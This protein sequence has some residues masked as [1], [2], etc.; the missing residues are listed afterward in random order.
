MPLA[1]GHPGH[2]HHRQ[3]A[4]GPRIGPRPLGLKRIHHSVVVAD[5]AVNR[6]YINR[7]YATCCRS[8][9]SAE[10]VTRH[11]DQAAP[12][13]PGAGCQDAPRPGSV[14]VRAPRARPRAAVPR[15]P[16]RARTSRPAFEGGQ[17]PL[18]M[19][20]PKLKG[21]KNRF[22]ATFQVV[23]VGQLAE[24]FPQGGTIGVADLVAAGRGPQ[25]PQVKV[26][27]DGD[28]NGVVLQITVD[29]V[30]GSAKEKIAAAGG[31]ITT[32]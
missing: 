21:F 14:A 10:G 31:S 32:A 11:D 16:A 26:L 9:S 24:L 8:R 19:R 30:S 12:P 6:G 25:G 4:A 7:A 22:R 18:H 13:A 23:N 5:N 3:Q 15:A 1:E 27:G 17:L 20:L 29:A 28:L 2:V